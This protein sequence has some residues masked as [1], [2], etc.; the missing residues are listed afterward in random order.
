MAWPKN[1]YQVVGPTNIPTLPTHIPQ[2]N[3]YLLIFH[4]SRNR[5]LQLE[6][7]WMGQ[8]TFPAWKI[9]CWGWSIIQVRH[10]HQHCSPNFWRRPTTCWGGEICK[11]SSQET[12]R[13]KLSPHT[14]PSNWQL[15]QRGPDWNVSSAKW[16]NF[17]GGRG[18]EEGRCDQGGVGHAQSSPAQDGQLHQ[19]EEKSSWEGK[20]RKW[21]KQR[22]D[23]SVCRHQSLFAWAFAGRSESNH[24]G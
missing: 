6:A 15:E 12:T 23:A 5:P 10:W 21:D 7:T 3:T 19:K 24:Y 17:V 11:R 4:Q 22:R 13:G 16:D 2:C 18:G 14:K 8:K 1:T 9:L 20:E